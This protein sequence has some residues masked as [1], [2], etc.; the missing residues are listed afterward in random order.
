MN[1]KVTEQ[2]VLNKLHYELINLPILFR[3]RVCEECNYSIPT[4]YR[5]M[6]GKEKLLEGKV[7]P[8]LSNAD[9]E[10]IKEI[11]EGVKNH[12]INSISTI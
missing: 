9:R 12:L 6:R 4:Y 11:G 7:V 2:N 5:K 8:A 1:K 10:K 3:N